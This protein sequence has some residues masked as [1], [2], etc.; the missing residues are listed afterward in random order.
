MNNRETKTIIVNQ[1]EKN[2]SMRF[3][4]K[5]HLIALAFSENEDFDQKFIIKY[6][7]ED[8]TNGDMKDAKGWIIF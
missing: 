8:G 6:T 7:K 2:V 4:T 3:I 5:N 1:V